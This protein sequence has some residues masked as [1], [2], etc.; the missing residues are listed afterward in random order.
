M[1]GKA[2][3]YSEESRMGRAN[4][5]GDRGGFCEGYRVDAVV[6]RVES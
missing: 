2:G 6:E 5:V 3:E 1:V 4:L